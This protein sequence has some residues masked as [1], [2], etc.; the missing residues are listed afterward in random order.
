MKKF[1]LLLV[2][3]LCYCGVFA[4]SVSPHEKTTDANIHGHVIDKTTGE[5]LAYI[6]VMLKGTTMGVLTDATGHYYM[7]NIPEGTY[8]VEVK[9]LGYATFNREITLRP[10]ATTELNFSILP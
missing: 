1:V 5:H 3:I 8:V 6:S 7:E 2:S 9:S 10:G 4:K